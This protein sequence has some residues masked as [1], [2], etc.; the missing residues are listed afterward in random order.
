MCFSSTASFSASALLAATGVAS[1]AR[2]TNTPQK[3][4]AGVPVIFSVQQFTEG[5]LWMSLTHPEWHAWQGVATYLFQIFA[6]VVW[7]FYIPLAVLLFEP[8]RQRRQVIFVLFGCGI[9][10]ALFSSFCLYWYPVQA[11]IGNHHIRYV[12]G[13]PLA[14]KWYYGLI[15]FL[16]TIL[17]PVISSSRPL[18]WL[19]YL[20]LMSYAASRLLFHFYE[21]SVWCFFGALIS[22]TI[23]FTINS[24]RRQANL[25]IQNQ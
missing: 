11:V 22:F 2:A 20:F 3:V 8:E 17:A 12:P 7:P 15:Y 16:P 23:F 5:V 24:Q 1:F 10:L 21:I 25:A 18:R 6:Q 14:Q 19:G 13:F 9:A 4:L